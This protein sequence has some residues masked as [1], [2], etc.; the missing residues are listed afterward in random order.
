[1]DLLI[2]GNRCKTVGAYDRRIVRAIV[3]FE[4]MKKW[5]NKDTF[6][7]E[8]TPYNLEVWMQTFPET[9]VDGGTPIAGLT[10]AQGADFEVVRTLPTYT[11]KNPPGEHQERALKKWESKDS[12]A[13]LMDMGTGKTYTGLTKAALRYCAGE[14]EHLLIIARNGV[15]AQ[16][17]FDEAPKHYSSDFPYKA[18]VFGKLKRDAV[19]FDHL[20]RFVGLKIFCINIDAINTKTGEERIMQFLRAARG[21]AMI[22]VDESQD[23]KE[24]SSQ[25]TKA[26]VRFGKLAR[27]KAI[28]TGTPIG[29]SVVDLFS[30]FNFLDEAILGH[31][32]ITTFRNRYCDFTMGDHGPVV[33]G[34]KNVEE[35]YRKIDPYSFR[36]TTEECYDMPERMWIPKHF[37]LTELQLKLMKDLKD[38]FFAEFAG[39]KILFVKNAAGLIMRM[40]QISCGFL[41]DEEGNL[42]RLNSNPRMDE[43]RHIIDQLSGKVIIWARFQED[44]ESIKAELGDQAIA[45]YGKTKKGDERENVKRQFIDDST[46]RFLVANPSVAG[47]GLDGF[48][49]VCFTNIYYSNSFSALDRWQS[50]RRTWRKGTTHP[51]TYFD[52]VANKSPDKRILEILKK[53]RDISDLTLDEFR[54]LIESEED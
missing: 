30:Q 3:R 36:I 1:M 24:W 41:P 8:N 53:N 11:H 19:A 10:E 27:Y 5:M 14:S 16:W 15:H 54:L 31:R 13:L 33:V 21:R 48:Q 2:D 28:L 23:I 20:L 25:R 12:F 40:Q 7:F 50:E 32:F 26:A 22:Y 34:H 44:I 52:L 38:N 17:A 51:V 4:G 43:L 9:K 49:S 29:K 42:I 46:T 35:L 47:A 18:V 6:S 39:D 37:A 45:Y